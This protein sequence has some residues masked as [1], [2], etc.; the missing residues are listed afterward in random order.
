MST[1]DD[2]VSLTGGIDHF[3]NNQGGVAHPITTEVIDVKVG[4]D[5][6]LRAYGE[7]VIAEAQRTN[8]T[9]FN[10][11]PI[12]IEEIME[13]AQFLLQARVDLVNGKAGVRVHQF[14]QLW[15]P[16][17]I[18]HVLSAIGIVDYYKIG[19]R[20]RPIVDNVESVPRPNESVEDSSVPRPNESIEDSSADS[21]DQQPDNGSTYTLKSAEAFSYK[22]SKYRDGLQ[23]VQN[24]MPR[25]FK[26]DPDVMS[27]AVIND[28]VRS[29]K[30]DTHPA[31]AYVAAFAGFQLVEQTS[32]AAL[33]RI[34][35]DDTNFIQG[36]FR[37]ARGIL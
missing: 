9:L 23:M 28:Y 14:K 30:Q 13:Y 16:V 34:Q 3:L 22:L 5:S 19:L 35:Y 21:Q 18:Q 24:A 25:D 12:T 15:I 11:E 8:P 27:C 33:Y 37:N 32:L 36:M 10:V 6:M 1:I 31:S 20:V 26:G 17:F 7:A 29:L 2:K 4:A